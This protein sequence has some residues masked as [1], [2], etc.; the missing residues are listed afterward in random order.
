[1]RRSRPVIVAAL[2]VAVAIAPRLSSPAA[3]TA[4]PA[5]STAPYIEG[6][7]FALMYIPRLRDRVWAL[8]VSAGAVAESLSKGVAHMTGT[9]MPGALGNFAVAGHRATHGAPLSDIDRL[10]PGDAVIVR[11][12]SNWFVYRLDRDA[13]VLPDQSWV[14]DPVPG[15]PQVAP[16]SRL[17]TLVTCEPRLG[18]EKR[19]I[20][21]GTLRSVLPASKRPPEL[22]G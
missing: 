7:S 17:I 20:W 5:V 18:H 14:T 2:V 13:M 4:R 16:V 9:A 12:K 11:T 22:R 8:P 3:A 6:D 10:R 21:W 15:N 19:W 1:M